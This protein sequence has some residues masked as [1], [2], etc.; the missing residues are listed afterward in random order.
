MMFPSVFLKEFYFVYPFSATLY[1]S[2][3]VYA[4]RFV[5]L[6]VIV[7]VLVYAMLLKS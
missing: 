4:K 1:G 7:G 5:P 3:L 2:N 6:L